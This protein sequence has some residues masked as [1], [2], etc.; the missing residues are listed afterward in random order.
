MNDKKSAT[1]IWHDTM[2]NSVNARLQKK[3]DFE[4]SKVVELISIVDSLIDLLE[5]PELYGQDWHQT[6]KTAIYRYRESLKKW[7]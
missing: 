2:D 6:K 4:H 1:E 7:K 3:L 5:S